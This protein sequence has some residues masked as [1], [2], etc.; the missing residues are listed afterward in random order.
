NLLLTL[1]LVWK[2]KSPVLSKYGKLIMTFN[3]NYSFFVRTFTVLLIV[4]L[5]SS[6]E[7][8]QVSLRNGSQV[9]APLVKQSSDSVILDMGYDVLRI[10]AREVLS[11]IEDVEGGTTNKVSHDNYSVADSQQISTSV[12]SKKYAEAVVVVKSP[13]GLGSGFIVNKDGYLVTNFH[14][15]KGARHLTVTR[16]K[17]DD[18]T[19]KR[20]IHRDVEIVA[21][22]PFYDLAVLKIKDQ[23]DDFTTVILSPS[24]D[25]DLGETVFAIGNPLGL[26][27]TVT[28]GVVSQSERSF[29]GHLYLQIDAPVNPG[30][31]GGPLFNGRGQVIGVIN[32]GVTGMEGL[33]FAIPVRDVKY[34]LDHL[35]G[36]AFDQSN[37][38]SG[39]VYP[40]PP[41]RFK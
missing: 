40:E 29:N 17:Q 39:Y 4:A 32:M 20:I 33:N 35:T 7:A 19:L 12:A 1:S 9:Q 3:I 11:V 24:D 18:A 41:P 22:A 16:F 38:E 37:P 6:L 14:V 8:V 2:K 34:M 15:I 21:T 30:N 31:S 36:F 26:E 10:P 23:K 28:E 5:C 13:H 27:R 25:V